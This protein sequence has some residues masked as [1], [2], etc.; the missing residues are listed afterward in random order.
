MEAAAHGNS[1][2]GIPKRVGLE[3]VRADE[4][5]SKKRRGAKEATPAPK[6]YTR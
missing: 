3:F 4:R 1:N 2:L 5:L 6:G